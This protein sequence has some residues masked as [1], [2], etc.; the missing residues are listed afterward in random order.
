MELGLLK[1]SARGDVIEVAFLS[2]VGGDVEV[3]SRRAVH[4]PMLQHRLFDAQGGLEAHVV[5]PGRIW[6]RVKDRRAGSDVAAWMFVAD[7]GLQAPAVLGEMRRCGQETAG[8][9]PIVQRRLF[10]AKGDFEA[11]V[12]WWEDVTSRSRAGRAWSRVAVWAACCKRWLGG[13]AAPL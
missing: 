13:M 10:V 3:R 1:S 2:G 9:D 12:V 8:Q 7:G 11:P 4:G 6:R 5:V